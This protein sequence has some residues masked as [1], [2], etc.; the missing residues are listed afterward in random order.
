MPDTQTD[1]VETEETIRPPEKSVITD[2]TQPGGLAEI[3]AAASD[4]A[5]SNDDD[6][7]TSD[8]TPKPRRKR[9]GR[10]SERKLRKL[11]R[12]LGDSERTNTANQ[13]R[14]AELEAKVETL[15][16]PKPSEPKFEDFDTPQAYGKAFAKW[17]GAPAP[18]APDPPKAAASPDTTPPPTAPPDKEMQAFRKAGA[19]KY[20]D[21]FTEA[22]ADETVAISPV[23]GD[24][25]LDSDIGPDV[26]L[27]LADNPD[28]ARE[29]ANKSPHSAVK[30]LEAIE[31]QAKAGKL[32]LD[33]GGLRDIEVE[34]G[35]PPVATKAPEPPKDQDD[36]GTVTI[37]A[38][39]ENESMDEYAARRRKEQAAAGYR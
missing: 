12:Q 1:K 9:S 5:G 29:I 19:E 25:I 26:Y 35:E 4:P 6:S 10:A 7:A 11:E 2:D 20:G 3:P 14:I 32:D 16:N 27:H 21:Q 34:T 38:D 33:D 28:L 13:T 24:F 18:K 36:R 8:D 39:P 17:E 15:A 22:L 30:R 37:K 31:Q 23:M